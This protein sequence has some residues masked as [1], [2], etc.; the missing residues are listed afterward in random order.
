[1]ELIPVKV[2]NELFDDMKRGVF[3][4]DIYC[5]YHPGDP[6]AERTEQMWSQ[7]Y[8]DQPISLVAVSPYLYRQW[9]ETSV[10]S[11]MSLPLM[12]YNSNTCWANTLEWP[13]DGSIEDG[14]WIPGED[15][16]PG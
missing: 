14:R 7:H 8:I 6:V 3:A 10:S 1:M 16:Y 9:R 4:L 11:D 2:G 12:A 13:N 5:D 15:R